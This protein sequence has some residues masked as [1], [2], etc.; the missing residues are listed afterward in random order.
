MNRLFGKHA[1][2][3]SF[4]MVT[5]CVYSFDRET[6]GSTLL[7]KVVKLLPDYTASHPTVTAMRNSHPKFPTKTVFADRPRVVGVYIE[8]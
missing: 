5:C 2:P 8:T 4:L 1:L 7:R 6:E 3:T